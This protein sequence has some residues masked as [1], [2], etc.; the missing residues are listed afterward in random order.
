[1][2]KILIF[3]STGMLGSEVLKVF[4]KEK[5]FIITATYKKKN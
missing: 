4:A 2:K 3:G 5:N 1:M